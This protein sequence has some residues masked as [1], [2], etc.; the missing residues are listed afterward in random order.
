[1]SSSSR[2]LNAVFTYGRTIPSRIA[3]SS[4]DQTISYETLAH[5]IRI[6]MDVLEPYKGKCV[7]IEMENSPAWVIA[8]LACIAL[9]I[10]TVPIPLFFTKEQR[11]HAH[12]QAGICAIIHDNLSISPQSY[13]PTHILPVTSKITFTSGSTALPKGVCLSQKG[14]EE[15]AYSLLKRIG[16][17]AA[18][19]TVALLPLSI[20]LENIA[21]CYTTL[22]AGGTYD[23]PP[24][25][26]I[27]MDQRPFPNFARMLAYLSSSK[28]TSCILVPELLRGLIQ[29]Q[30][31]VPSD[32]THMQFMAVGGAH[33][34]NHLLQQAH[35]LGLPV[36][37]GYGLS[38]HG[39]VISVNTPSENNMN[40]VGKPLPHITLSIADD[41]EILL[42]D[43]IFLGYLGRSNTAPIFASGDL[44][45]IDHDGYL[46]I[47]GRKKN[48][49]ITSFGRNISPEWPESEL[50]SQTEIHQCLVYGD[51]TAYLCALIV[52]SSLNVSN[53]SIQHAI[54][55]TN[56]ILPDYAHIK[57]WASV[58]PF[59]A[60]DGLLT[61]NGR[62]KRQAIISTYATLLQSLYKEDMHANIL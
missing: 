26:D 10:I 52:P 37:Q 40:S 4:G 38:E 55:R 25:H 3:L 49:L 32:L 15:V 30:S 8:D 19:K 56:H 20:L 17:K 53:A 23:I 1:M 51:A 39:S 18:T 21:G 34:A 13:E 59:T 57:T 62:I 45:S 7:A 16:K 28:A 11:L 47:K 46:Y 50:L 35:R 6:F 43:P 58:T 9:N 24:S 36:Y 60:D 61:G 22:I 2:I 12:R 48:I 27:G 29:R 54:D 14:I 42:H 33:V 44:G 41:G 31:M 5:H